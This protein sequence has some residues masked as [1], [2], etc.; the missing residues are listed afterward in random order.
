[1]SIYELIIL[2]F[3]L[4]IDAMLVS[5]SYGLVI[6][7][8]RIKN[9]LILAFFFGLFQFIMPFFGWLMTEYIYEYLHKYSKWIVFIIF[10]MLG[11][12]FIKD[13]FSECGEKPNDCISLLC[14]FV[15]AL[16]TS[17]DAFGAGV[18]LRFLEVD[19]LRVCIMIGIVTFVLSIA[20]F[21]FGNKFNCFHKKYV[22]V[23][24][25]IML[26][27]LALKALFV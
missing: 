27:Y 1:M 21:Y 2:S 22:T 3:A 20:G 7:A 12:K 4:A 18:S 15:L 16:A 9:S 5:F 14:V 26:I 25:G 10:L 24:G 6:T 17:I 11:L 19:I 13:A 8:K 23:T